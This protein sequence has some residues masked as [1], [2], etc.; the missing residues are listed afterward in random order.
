MIRRTMYLERIRPFFDS[1]LIKVIVGVRRCG[2]SVLLRQIRDELKADGAT[3]EQLILIDFD[4]YDNRRLFNPDT[5]HKHVKALIKRIEKGGKAYL[6][7]D[8]VQ[9]VS[10]FEVVVNSLNNM[11]ETSIFITGSNS[12]LL[13]G[14]LATKLG[15]RT[16]SFRMMPFNF[17]EFCKFAN[18]EAHCG[19]DAHVRAPDELL[20]HYL[21][22]GGFPLVSAQPDD[23]SK[24]VVLDNLYSSIVLRDI[25]QRNRISSAITLEN[26]LDYLIANSSATI[27]GNNIAATLSDSARK[28][29]APTVYDMIRSIE[30]SYVISRAERFDIRGKKVLSFE[31]KEYVCDLGFF[32]MRKNRIKDEWSCIVETAVFNELVSRGLHVYIGKTHRGEIDF[33][34]EQSGKRCYI[35]AAYLL[36]TEETR[37]REF[38]AYSAISD[39]HP[40]YVISMD[41]IAMSHDGITHL[42]LI[43]FLSDESLLHLN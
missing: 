23:E 18:D 31:A 41:P 37:R 36:P 29:S 12:K 11:D 17:R 4:D 21:K 3:P 39:N 5:L 7:F 32:Q 13:S 24:R 20:G 34:A 9:N 42:R 40:K 10:D 30:E 2:K 1:P 19:K 25:I 27:S 33:I 43:D 38:G 6:F 8:E 22:W 15:G 14:E 16:L 26:V 35:Q 28:V